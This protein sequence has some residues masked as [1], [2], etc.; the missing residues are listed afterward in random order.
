MFSSSNGILF[1]DHYVQELD[2]RIGERL[3][4]MFEI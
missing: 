2:K 1:A 3:S 4:H